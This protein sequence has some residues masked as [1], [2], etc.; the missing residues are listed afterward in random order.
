MPKKA[1]LR[2][3]LMVVLDMDETLIHSQLEFIG[4]GCTAQH[5]PRQA[6]DRS[7]SESDTSAMHDFEFGIP[8]D[9]L[10]GRGELKVKVHKRPGLD[11]FLEEASSFCTLAVFTAGTEDYAKVLLEKLDPCG[12]MS[13]RLYR[14]SCSVVDGLFLKDLRKL[15]HDLSRV[16]LVDNSPVSLLI[17]PDNSILVSSFYTDREDRALPQLLTILRKLHHSGDVRG[18]LEEQFQ[19]R[20]ALEQSGWDLEGIQRRHLELQQWHELGG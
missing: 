8:V 3:R 1:G 4:D 6:E 9:G 14:D 20:E 10:V 11:E 15:E 7:C 2:E 16:V 17:N 5:D 19:L 12:R 18:A 13:L